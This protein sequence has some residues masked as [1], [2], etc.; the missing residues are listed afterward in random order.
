MGKLLGAKDSA[1]ISPVPKSGA[2]VRYK[3]IAEKDKERLRKFGSKML[4][5]IFVGYEQQAG[6]GWSGDLLLADWDE[7][8][9]AE[10]IADMCVKRFKAKEVE[11]VKVNGKERFPLAEGDLKQPG[12]ER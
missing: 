5:G 12:A 1:K 9:N 4:S 10:C 7:I 6:G 11:V 3:P 2:E 8:E